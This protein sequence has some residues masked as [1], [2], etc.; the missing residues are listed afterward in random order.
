[1]STRIG[2]WGDAA[3][4]GG[5]VSGKPVAD[6]TSGGREAASFGRIGRSV[7]GQPGKQCSNAGG[8][9]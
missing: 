7:F 3:D 1:M 9:G 2:L 6:G 4:V 8:Q 5:G